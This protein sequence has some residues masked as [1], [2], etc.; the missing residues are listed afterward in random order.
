[1]ATRSTV[2]F[3]SE[4]TGSLILNAYHQYDGYIGGVG[5]DLAKFLKNKKII[6]GISNQTID[7][8]YAN[9]MGCL[10]AQYVA[11]NKNSIGS[12]YLADPEDYQEYN[13]EVR[14]VDGAII[15]WVDD[16]KGTPEELLNYTEV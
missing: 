2:K 14:L 4:I 6:N 16:F 13:Y 11:V 1:M 8:G 5:H 9:G 3:Y 12:F 10:A 7:G 15:I